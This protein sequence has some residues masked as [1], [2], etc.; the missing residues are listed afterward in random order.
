MPFWHIKT[1][2]NS[3]LTPGGPRAVA[4]GPSSGVMLGLATQLPHNASRNGLARGVADAGELRARPFLT[5]Q[6]ETKNGNACVTISGL[7]C[8]AIFRLAFLIF[9]A[10]FLKKTPPLKKKDATFNKKKPHLGLS[11][12]G[13]VF[14]PHLGPQVKWWAPTHACVRACAHGQCNKVR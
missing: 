12:H 5:S 3:G 2:T 6:N 10:L 9:S 13:F 1:A 11:R 8:V 14:C 7:A 4:S